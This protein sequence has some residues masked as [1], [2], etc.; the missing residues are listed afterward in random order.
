[1]SVIVYAGYNTIFSL[2]VEGVYEKQENEIDFYLSEGYKAV[3]YY[4]YPKYR[5]AFLVRPSLPGEASQYLPN[6]EGGLIVLGEFQ[7]SKVDKI[8]KALSFLRTKED[9]IKTLKRN[10]LFFRKLG[11]V[12]QAK[13][14]LDYVLLER[15][16]LSEKIKNDGL[17]IKQRRPYRKKTDTQSSSK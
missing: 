15:F 6:V 12:L 11:F 8:K 1:M 16:Y 3:L 5:K 13:G 9:V 7:R 2:F 17:N 10:D 4:T 14:R